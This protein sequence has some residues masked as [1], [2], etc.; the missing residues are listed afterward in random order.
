MLRDSTGAHHLERPPAIQD[1]ARRGRRREVALFEAVADGATSAS[2]E[3]P[4]VAVRERSDELK[5]PVPGE[6]EIELNGCRARVTTSR[7]ARSS[8]SSPDHPSPV[9]G[10]NGPCVRMV[11]VPL[12][13]DAERQLVMIGVMESNDRGMTVMR[14]RAD[15][16]V[17]EVPDPAGDASFLTLKNPLIR[18]QGHW[19]LEFTL[20]PASV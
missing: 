10:L 4:Y 2:V 18:M 13:S 15:P 20:P 17:I 11:L 14:S 5:V 8:D 7:V 6:G 12:D 1:Q 19:T 16:P 9:A 3:I